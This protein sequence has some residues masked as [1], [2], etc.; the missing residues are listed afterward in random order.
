M[1]L[2]WR[3][4]KNKIDTTNHLDDNDEV[5]YE[6]SESPKR[7]PSGR[8][9]GSFLS[10]F[11]TF[12]LSFLVVISVTNFAEGFRRLLELGLYIIFKDKLKLEP[13]EITFLLGIMAFPWVLKIFI[14]IFT[15]NISL[16][17]S[18][19]RNYIII[20]AIFNIIS[21]LM[22]MLFGVHFGKYF[23]MGCIITS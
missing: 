18:R 16:F 5:E 4:H 11:D 21:I 19:R 23:I 2:L 13:A 1:S 9:H 15:D 6:G 7:H 22:L 14:A 20:N 3:K 8:I 12:D 10:I 17:G